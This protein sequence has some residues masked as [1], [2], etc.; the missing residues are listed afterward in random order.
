MS[1]LKSDLERLLSGLKLPSER[2]NFIHSKLKRVFFYGGFMGWARKYYEKQLN[3]EISA[4]TENI[5]L[6]YKGQSD[7]IVEQISGMYAEKNQSEQ[8][9]LFYELPSLFLKYDRVFSEPELNE[10]VE[11]LKQ[12]LKCLNTVRRV[13]VTMLIAKFAEQSN[14]QNRKHKAGEAT[15]KTLEA[16][17]RSEQ[18]RR[19]IEYG[20]DFIFANERT[21]F[22]VPHCKDYESHNVKA[23]IAIQSSTNDRARMSMPKLH[24]GAKRYLCSLNGCDSSS[25]DTSQISDALAR[26]FRENEIYYVIIEKE[27]TK[28]ISDAKQRILKHMGTNSIKEINARKRLE[29]LEKFTLNY[30][31]FLKELKEL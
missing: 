8:S 18:W 13:R 27:R 19:G 4:E 9:V 24:F 23:Y 5:L 12:N 15:A 25:K 26:S 3:S 14:S 11:T 17:F 7:Q 30:D 22:T 16:L 1:E 29:W 20:R 6:N 28:A 2:Y 31:Q 21:D 10:A